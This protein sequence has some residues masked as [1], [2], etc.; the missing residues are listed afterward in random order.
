MTVDLVVDVGNSRIKW[1]RCRDGCV[2]ETVSLNSGDRS[3]WQRQL[4]IW[5]LCAASTW[6]VSGVH[7]E[8][9][10]EFVDWL[11]QRGDQV[12]H[13]S[14][15]RQ[16]PLEMEVDFPDQVGID[17]LLNAVAAGSRIRGGASALI[18]DAGT[19]V[20]VDWVDDRGVFRGGAISPGFRLMAQALHDHT[21]LLPLVSPPAE[22]ARPSVPGTSTIKAIQAG[23]F[24]SV[25]GG[26]RA[27]I[28][29]MTENARLSST[30]I[31]L[32]GGDAS[33]LEPV[34]ELQSCY[35]QQMTLEG[36][37]IAAEGGRLPA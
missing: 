10:Q 7:P 22:R 37:R 9:V 18:V 16:L 5:R 21:A 15:W 32:T 17:R 26:V 33:L 12:L 11:Q 14:S 23:V 27:L 30:Q 20:T 29:Q 1:G 31:F 3:S 8:R 4:D 35:W 25:V 28:S 6:A 2:A 13:L 19:A 24:W 34:L 36:I